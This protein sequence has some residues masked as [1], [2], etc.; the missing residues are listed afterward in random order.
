MLCLNKEDKNHLKRGFSAS[1]IFDDEFSSQINYLIQSNREGE[2]GNKLCC[3]GEE[4]K[5][6]PNQEKVP[7]KK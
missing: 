1:R 3:W 4:F 7:K 2:Q 5:S 6:L